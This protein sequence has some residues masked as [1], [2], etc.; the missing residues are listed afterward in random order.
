M[1]VASLLAVLGATAAAPP[2]EIA[3]G[4]REVRIADVAALTGFGAAAH[5]RFASR[6]I[7]SIPRGRTRLSMT[8]DALVGLVGRSVPGLA[9]RM[10]PGAGAV[11]FHA[12]PHAVDANE[13][14]GGCS[15]T[16][17][18]IAEGTAL[19]PADI[20]TVPCDA[21]PIDAGPIDAPVRFDRRA[22]ALRASVALAAG[23]RLGRIALPGAPD[24]DSGDRLTLISAVGPVRV[25]RQVVALQAGRSGGRV[26]VRDAEGQV[27][28]APL[29]VAASAEE[30]R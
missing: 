21:G 10:M 24:V 12:L 26:F 27:L 9:G 29:A 3:L 5:P 6:V 7:A 17:Q 15:A 28:A 18:P 8:R 1:L 20:V 22:S 13:I 4:G 11:T 23:T 2:V 19:T 14:Q 16:A 30:S 25:E